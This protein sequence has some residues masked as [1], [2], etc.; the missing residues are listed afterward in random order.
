M[1]FLPIIY[2]GKVIHM[3]QDQRFGYPDT[4]RGNIHVRQY[5]HDNAEKIFL[6]FYSYIKTI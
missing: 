1:A 6:K 5:Y 4:T 3:L 2:Y